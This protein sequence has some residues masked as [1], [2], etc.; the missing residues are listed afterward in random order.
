VS[1]SAEAL[2]RPATHADLAGI[3]AI[4]AEV[5]PDFPERSAVLD[6]KRLLFSQGCFCFD[7]NGAVLGYALSHP[8]TLYDIPP[9]DR[10]LEAIPPDADCLYLHDVALLDAARGGGAARALIRK[11]DGVARQARLPAIALTSVNGTR[12]LWEALGFA[13][14][15]DKRLNV[16]SYGGSAV[17]MIK[18]LLPVEG[19]NPSSAVRSSQQE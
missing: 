16:D 8:W 19:E 14:V 1:L 13:P 2:W 11:L 10:F 6:E 4:A 9:L 5:H 12:P 3:V 7:N 15:S 17:Y 18:R